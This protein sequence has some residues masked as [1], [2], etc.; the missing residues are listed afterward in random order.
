VLP[1][2]DAHAE[3]IRVSYSL[4]GWIYQIHL[5]FYFR[6]ENPAYPP[7]QTSDKI[8]IELAELMYRLPK[9]EAASEKI[10][11]ELVE[12]YGFGLRLAVIT[13]NKDLEQFSLEHLPQEVTGPNHAVGLAYAAA[14]NDNKEDIV[15]YMSIGYKDINQ[16]HIKK[17]VLFAPYQAELEKVYKIAFPYNVF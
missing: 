12:L 9:L 7:Q 16:S 4:Q 5:F 3:K 11:N 2:L 8:L 6:N 10:N 17:D 1:D 15:K 14:A 13:K